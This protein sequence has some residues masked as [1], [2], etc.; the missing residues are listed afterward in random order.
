MTEVSA[1]IIEAI[2]GWA[3]IAA[4]VLAWPCI[5][6]V[7]E[8]S[9]AIIEA[10]IEAISGW[11]RIAAAV[12]AWPCIFCLIDASLSGWAEAVA[13]AVRV[14]AAAVNAMAARRIE[15]LILES[16]FIG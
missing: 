6:F 16:S 14:A 13:E 11:A 1:A 7:T 3:R 9:A 5:F 2:W 12:L 15:V 8:V 4:A 10:I